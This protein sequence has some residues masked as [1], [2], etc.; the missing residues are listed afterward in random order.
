MSFKVRSK[1]LNILC[2][3]R[4]V[5][6]QSVC[7]QLRKQYDCF[8]VDLFP[9]SNIH[10]LL[11]DKS[12]FFS[13]DATSC[14]KTSPVYLHQLLSE[15]LINNSVW[16]EMVK[17]ILFADDVLNGFP[18]KSS[19]RNRNRFCPFAKH[20]ALLTVSNISIYLHNFCVSEHWSLSDEIKCGSFNS[21]II[22]IF[23]LFL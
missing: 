3:A 23:I 4:H 1:I 17:S 5:S 14:A 16:L 22:I 7:L 15:K 10:L 20:A 6:K 18:I 13:P 8:S 19:A 12:A 21:I 11:D 9:F 2:T